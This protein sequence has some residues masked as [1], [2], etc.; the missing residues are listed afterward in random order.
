MTILSQA[1]TRFNFIRFWNNNWMVY[2][3]F[4]YFFFSFIERIFARYLKLIFRLIKFFKAALIY[5][6]MKILRTSSIFYIVIYLYDNLLLNIKKSFFNLR[7][8]KKK[9]SFLIDTLTG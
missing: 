7:L 3:V 8:K 9:N 2:K 5:S 1:S 6:N 4:N